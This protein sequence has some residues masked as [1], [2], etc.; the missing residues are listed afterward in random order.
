MVVRRLA[1]DAAQDQISAVASALQD[2]QVA[3]D[4]GS[5]TN[6][7]RCSI[8][9]NRHAEQLG[10]DSQQVCFGLRMGRHEKKIL[11]DLLYMPRKEG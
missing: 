4:D 8:A 6:V 11:A 1:S 7:P 9:V 10:P 3:V 5:L 2:L